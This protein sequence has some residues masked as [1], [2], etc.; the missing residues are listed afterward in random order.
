MRLFYDA[1]I[2]IYT[3]GGSK[4]FSLSEVEAGGF[5]SQSFD[6]KF[7][8]GVFKANNFIKKIQFKAIGSKTAGKII[9]KKIVNGEI[10]NTAIAKDRDL[11]HFTQEIIDSPF[12]LYTKG[13]SWENDVFQKEITLAQIES[14]LLEME[15]PEEALSIVENTYNNFRVVGKSLI[16]LEILF[17]SRGVSFICDL[18]GERFFKKNNQVIDI[19]EVFNIIDKKKRNVERPV[20]SGLNLNNICPFM[21]NYGKLVEALSIAVINHVCKKLSDHKSIPKQI[22]ETAMIERFSHKLMR[23]KD[24]Y[25]SE[26]VERLQAA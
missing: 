3:E 16:K 7:W 23:E 26:I 12:I 13:Y 22:I 11:D 14:M 2:V 18:N 19:K 5:S 15:M 9:T 17:R 20:V 4:S 24:H 8:Y 21:N 10:K 1:D 25:Y 6:I